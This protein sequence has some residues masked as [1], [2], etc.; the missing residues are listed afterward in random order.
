MKMELPQKY[1]E[2]GLSTYH[3]QR[4]KVQP[5]FDPPSF[6]VETYLPPPLV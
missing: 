1:V 3:Q 2:N 6:R 4:A 5:K